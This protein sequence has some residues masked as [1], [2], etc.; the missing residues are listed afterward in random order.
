MLAGVLENVR[1]GAAVERKSSRFAMEDNE[2][3]W[4]FG[5][6]DRRGGGDGLGDAIDLKLHARSSSNCT[7]DQSMSGIRAH[8]PLPST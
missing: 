4:L 5:V 6:P 7:S 1:E 8:L 2:D 3:R